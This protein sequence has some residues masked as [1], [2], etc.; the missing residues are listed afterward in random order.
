MRAVPASI[1]RASLRVDSHVRITPMTG[2]CTWRRSR[3][4]PNDPVV[5]RQVRRERRFDLNRGI[6]ARP[7]LR[8]PSA[9]AR[10]AQPDAYASF[11]FS[12]HHGATTSLAA[13]H[14]FRRLYAE[15]LIHGVRSASEMS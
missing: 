11:E 14:A 3:T 10:F 15:V 9:V 5:N 6:R 8:L 4:R 2:S 13:F 1:L 12:F 7:A